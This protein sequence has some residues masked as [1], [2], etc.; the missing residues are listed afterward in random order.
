MRIQGVTRYAGRQKNLSQQ[1]TRKAEG[2]RRRE[3][4]L[5][6]SWYARVSGRETMRRLAG[7][8]RVAQTCN[9]KQAVI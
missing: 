1:A 3:H 4:P 2:L 7:S 9:P 8:Q 6:K 5:D